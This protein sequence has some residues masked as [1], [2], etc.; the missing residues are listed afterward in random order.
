MVGTGQGLEEHGV[1]V[2]ILK[3][4]ILSFIVH[5]SLKISNLYI[6]H[7]YITQLQGTVRHVSNNDDNG[8]KH[9]H[10]CHGFLNNLRSPTH[11]LDINGDLRQ[12]M[13]I[14]ER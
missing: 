14:P 1:G 2:V 3:T 11:D 12:N 10:H 13:V 4:H 9:V 8:E 5:S 6:H 7:D